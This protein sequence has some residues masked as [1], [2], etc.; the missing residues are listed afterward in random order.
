MGSPPRARQSTRPAGSARPTTSSTSFSSASPKGWC[1]PTSV[2]SPRARAA[3]VRVAEG[4]VLAR[5][6]RF[7]EAERVGR[8]AVELADGTDFCFGRPLAHSYFAETL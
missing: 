7:P 5:E 6:R 3:V 4:L 8:Q 1:S 2:G